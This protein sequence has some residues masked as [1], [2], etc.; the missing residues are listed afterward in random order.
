MPN[1]GCG[2]ND[3]CVVAISHI[4]R[5]LLLDMLLVFFVQL[6]VFLHGPLS[7]LILGPDPHVLFALESSLARN[8]DPSL[9]LTRETP[10]CRCVM[11]FSKESP[12]KRPTT[13]YN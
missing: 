9:W 6:A 3:C 4:P 1:S 8:E 7:R 10:S 2:Q 11:Y 12:H 5:Y 13:S